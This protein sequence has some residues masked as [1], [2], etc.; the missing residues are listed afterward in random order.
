MKEYQKRHASKSN[1]PVFTTLILALFFI[2][3]TSCVSKKKYEALL[4]EN[5]RL[6]V[7][8]SFQGYE[9]ADI[10]YHK[11][12]IIYV[13]K[14]ELLDKAYEIDSLKDKIAD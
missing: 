5:A 13:N 6:T 7:N 11:D 9:E 8:N 12:S 2:F 1:F 4:Q 10:V 14:K 3:Q